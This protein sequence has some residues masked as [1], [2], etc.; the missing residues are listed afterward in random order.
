MEPPHFAGA[1]AQ[2][3]GRRL[4]PEAEPHQGLRAH[5]PGGGAEQHGIAG[6]VGLV[7]HGLVLAEHLFDRAGR[8]RVDALDIEA[9]R[10]PGDV[11]DRD[12]DDIDIEQHREVGGDDLQEL[13]EARR[14][15]DRERR[16]VHP[17][18]ARQ[19]AAADGDQMAVFGVEPRQ[20]T[21]LALVEET[22]EIDNA[23][24]DLA[25]GWP[26]QPHRLGVRL[27]KVGM[28][29][30][31]GED[32][33][34]LNF[35]P[36][37][38]AP[39]DVAPLDVAPRDLGRDLVGRRGAARWSGLIAR[40]VN[41]SPKPTPWGQFPTRP[42]APG[43]QARASVADGRLPCQPRQPGDATSRGQPPA[44]IAAI[45]VAG[46]ARLSRGRRRGEAG[47][48]PLRAREPRAAQTDRRR[49]G[50]RGRRYRRRKVAP[51]RRGAADPAAAG[52]TA[53]LCRSRRAGVGAPV[54]RG[55]LAA[56]LVAEY[57]TPAVPPRVEEPDWRA[58]GPP[59][60]PAQSRAA[61]RLVE[62][63]E[64][65]G[66]HVTVLDGVTGSGKTETYF[67]AIAAA[68]AKGKQALV[69]LPEIA[70]SAQWLE[71]FRRRFGA[72]PAEWHSDIGQ[73]QRRDTWRAVADDDPRPPVG[74]RSAL[75][76]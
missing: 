19:I 9:R 66:F 8:D 35:A 37:D 56:G 32:I 17:V 2:E 13:P 16:L 20:F 67:A 18:L 27:E 21:A 39:L 6:R 49:L 22:L 11:L 41:H 55:L 30:K 72:N 64:T 7:D 68:L 65:G 45:A 31:I 1:D 61:M 75:F 47:A 24:A 42:R 15:E 62:R 48:R 44:R 23:V 69:L 33:A 34:P 63:V 43:S 51:A 50:R 76:L 29:A 4:A 12:G 58:A 38:V 28:P 59:L 54:V 36:L 57:L 70:L 40:T 46:G 60:S 14:R 3:A 25:A 74:A 26:Q 71:R 10:Y 5:Q 52:R 73:T 53:P